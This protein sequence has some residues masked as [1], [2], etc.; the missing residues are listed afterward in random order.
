M[1]FTA[2]FWPGV[3]QEMKDYCDS[4]PTCQRTAPTSHFR[5]PLVPLPI[6]EV[7]FDC[8]AMDMVG[9]LPK[10]A[11]GHQYI[12]VVLDYATRYPAAF[13]LRNCSSKVI[14]QELF[15]MFMR[16]GLPSEILRDQGTPFM[17]KVM[18]ELCKLFK[19]KHL[20]TSVYHLQTDGLVERL[21]KTLKGMLK[22]AVEEDGRD[23]D[24]LLPP[25]LFAIREVPQAS[26]GYSP[27]ELVYGRHP[28]GLLDIMKDVGTRSFPISECSRTRLSNAGPNNKSYAHNTGTFA[29]CAKCPESCIQPICQG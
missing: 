26:M 11:R 29:G 4:C 10:S 9:P 21:N 14:A 28:R 19:I 17:S 3:Y 24:C 22:K 12:L 8:I 23:C 15:Q 5:S 16:T 27:F 13:P 20:W 25:L 2:F 7:P 1:S 6:I 18:K